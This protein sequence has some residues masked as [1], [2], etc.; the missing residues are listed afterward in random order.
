M[1]RIPNISE[2]IYAHVV[3]FNGG[4]L[5]AVNDWMEVEANSDTFTFAISVT[6]AGNFQ[7][8]LECN[9]NGNGSWFT[10]DESKTINSNGQYAYF[11]TGRAVTKIR[12]RIASIASGSPVVTPHIAVTYEG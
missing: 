2:D 9:F 10:I 4:N 3:E 5:T 6:N 11:Y 1:A 7:L 8:A 12:L